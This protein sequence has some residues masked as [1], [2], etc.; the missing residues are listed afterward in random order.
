MPACRALI[1][2]WSAAPEILAN[3]RHYDG[4]AADVWS[5]GVMLYVSQTSLFHL[6][7]K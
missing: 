1:Q 3:S 5:A 6:L 4:F 2:I 7:Y